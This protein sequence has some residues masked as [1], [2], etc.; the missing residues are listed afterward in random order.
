MFREESIQVFPLQWVCWMWMLHWER[1]WNVSGEWCGEMQV[2]GS[3]GVGGGAVGSGF[4]GWVGGEGV[5]V[6][7]CV[8]VEVVEEIWY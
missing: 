8:V 3:F 2:G 6:W 4:W 5:G 1:V 7:I